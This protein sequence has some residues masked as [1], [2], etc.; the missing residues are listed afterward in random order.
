MVALQPVVV[1][2]PIRHGTIESAPPRGSYFKNLDSRFVGIMAGSIALHVCFLYFLLNSPIHKGVSI[3][4]A[5]PPSLTINSQQESL[6]KTAPIDNVVILPGW[7]PV[8]KWGRKI[9][10]IRKPKAPRIPSIWNSSTMRKITNSGILRLLKSPAHR[11]KQSTFSHALEY[12]THRGSSFDVSKMKGLTTVLPPAGNT[13]SRPK[14]KTGDARLTEISRMVDALPK[15]RSRSA[16]KMG[17]IVITQPVIEK[18]AS[19]LRTT[20]PKTIMRELRKYLPRIRGQFEAAFKGRPG[21]PG[22]VTVRFVVLQ[23]GTV[24]RAELVASTF[25]LPALENRIV[26]TVQRLTFRPFFSATPSVTISCPF[27]FQ[28]AQ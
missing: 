15:A 19:S 25:N 11:S 4:P 26:R 18:G 7:K 13:F 12:S 9:I 28:P 24:S 5:L 14:E 27:V 20:A 21:I 1:H 22:K 16:Q 23:D 10:R 2:S 8:G 3:F 6:T 17:S